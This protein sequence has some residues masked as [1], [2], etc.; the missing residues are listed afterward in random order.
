MKN[1]TIQVNKIFTEQ[2]AKELK[3]YLKAKDKE[4][5]NCRQKLIEEIIRMCKKMREESPSYE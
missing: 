5:V 3:E 4:V 1:Y 2:K